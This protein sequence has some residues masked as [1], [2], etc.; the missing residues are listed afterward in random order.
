MNSK[1]MEHIESS[2]TPG[3]EFLMYVVRRVRTVAQSQMDGVAFL[4]HQILFC[5]DWI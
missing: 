3:D 2:Q 1:L 5:I 4:V